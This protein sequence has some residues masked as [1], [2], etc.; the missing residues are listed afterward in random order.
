MA[1]EVG[2][3][4]AALTKLG[5]SSITA[6]TEDSTAAR[7]AN[8]RYADV[9]D[10][11]LHQHPWN[12]AMKRASIPAS[13][14]PAWGF[15]YACPVPTDYIRMYEVN[16]ENEKSGK[17]RVED[18][19]VVSD[20]T[21]PFEILYVYRV[22][23]PNKMSIGF[24]EALASTLANDWAEKITGDPSVVA[25]KERKAR[26]AVAQARSNDGQEGTPRDLE[27]DEWENSRY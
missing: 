17:W 23:D 4:N 9:R 20:L 8:D 18:G 25:D 16:G 14:A 10:A 15:T 3:A 24:R 12:F 7:L 5:Q 2:I 22:E 27:A 1:S 13:T 11:L 19:S 21:P 6:F 26:F